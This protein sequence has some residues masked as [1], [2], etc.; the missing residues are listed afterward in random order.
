[1]KKF[2]VLLLMSVVFFAKCKKGTEADINIRVKNAD[3]ITIDL[4]VIGGNTL[5][6]ENIPPGE[7]TEY[8]G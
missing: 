1:M 5:F 3:N 8:Q 7:T 6:Y 4:F 2:I